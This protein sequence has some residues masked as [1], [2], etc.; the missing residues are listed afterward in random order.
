MAEGETALRGRR[1]PWARN[2][3][4]APKE[5][6]TER[7]SLAVAML[8]YPVSGNTACSQTGRSNSH[9][10]E[11]I[12]GRMLRRMED[13]P[14]TARPDDVGGGGAWGDEGLFPNVSMV[15]EQGCAYLSNI[16]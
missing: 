14:A 10:A 7:E 16:V 12:G 1:R 11:G 9:W 6:K 15:F 4:A 3:R 2:M 8:A 13:H 5:E